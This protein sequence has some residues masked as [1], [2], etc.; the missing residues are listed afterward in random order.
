MHMDAHNVCRFSSYSLRGHTRPQLFRWLSTCCVQRW[1]SLI[2]NENTGQG[3]G[4]RQA[5]C[6]ADDHTRK[7][8]HTHSSYLSWLITTCLNTHVTGPSGLAL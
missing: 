6:R 1:P 3:V 5:H 2:Q 7:D 4:N 8:T